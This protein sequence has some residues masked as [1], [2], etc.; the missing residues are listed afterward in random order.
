MIIEII[1]FSLILFLVVSNAYLLSLIDHYRKI[2]HMT[3]QRNKQNIKRY[4]DHIE[5]LNKIYRNK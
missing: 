5:R 3:E 1:L 2:I 4:N